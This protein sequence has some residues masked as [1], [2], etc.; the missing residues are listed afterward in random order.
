MTE[1]TTDNAGVI[2]PPPILFAGCILAGVLIDLAWPLALLNDNWQYWIG[3]GLL[4]AGF[5]LAFA[6]ILL[7]HRAGTNVP[8]Y[9]PTTAL[10][11]DGPYRHSRNPMYIA[12]FLAYLGIGVM[13]D[14]GWML[15][16]TVPLF[17]VMNVGVI[18]REDR[19]LEGK[20]GAAY[21]E[22]KSRVRR[23]L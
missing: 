4:V 10:V 22:Y 2:A 7:F 8:P 16:L 9:R 3:G 6:C 18:A 1:H 20:F 19:Y 13:A 12:L 17:M 21:I 23:W 15:A 11:T 5:A 14:N